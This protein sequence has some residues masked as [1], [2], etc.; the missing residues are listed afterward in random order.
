[1]TSEPELTF[2][3]APHSPNAYKVR[4]LLALLQRPHRVVWLDILGGEAKSAEFKRHNPFGRVPFIE[5][6]DFGLAES[7]AILLYLASGT[8]LVPA[9][10]QP[11]ALLHQWMFFEQNQLELGCGNA[12]YYTRFRPDPDKVAIWRPRGEAALE[13]LEAHLSGREWLVGHSFTAADLALF[14]YSHVAGEGGIAM[15]R[16]PAVLRW[17][18]RVRSLPHFLPFA[19]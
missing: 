17:H 5:H 18:A 16:F 13:A 19:G 9:D 7:N 6:G 14:A 1:V 8:P 10:P 3:D 2:Y 4:L 15:E 12:R 11:H